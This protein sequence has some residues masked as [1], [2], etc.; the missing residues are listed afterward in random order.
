MFFFRFGLR[1]TKS[2]HSAFLCAIIAAIVCITNYQTA[3]DDICGDPPPVANE[4]IR[5]NIEGKAVGLAPLIGTAKFT[6]QME[7]SRTEIFSAYGEN[8]RSDAYFEYMICTLILKDTELTTREKINE[9]SRV[10]KRFETPPAT[11]QQQGINI[12]QSDGVAIGNNN[13]INVTK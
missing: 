10:W 9:I 11:S 3:A 5:G 4:V 2:L 1:H 7:H 13:E 8:E 12:Q 6:G